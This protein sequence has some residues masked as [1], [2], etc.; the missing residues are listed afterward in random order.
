MLTL[1]FQLFSGVFGVLSQIILGFCG[2]LSDVFSEAMEIEAE[3]SDD[4]LYKLNADNSDHIVY[5][6]F[7]TPHDNPDKYY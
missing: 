4:D 1:L 3:S 6:M 2:F 5:S 7:D